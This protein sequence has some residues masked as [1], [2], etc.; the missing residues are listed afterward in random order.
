MALSLRAAIACV[1]VPNRNNVAQI[2]ARF[3]TYP[4]PKCIWTVVSDDAPWVRL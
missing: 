4:P 2:T 3:M 1:D